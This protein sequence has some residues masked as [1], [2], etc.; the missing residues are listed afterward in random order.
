MKI[1][2]AVVTKDTQAGPSKYPAVPSSA[3]LE[4]PMTGK[5][6]ASLL[7]ISP[8]IKSRVLANYGS[9]PSPEEDSL[10]E[11][12]PT[13]LYI[14][15]KLQRDRMTLE[16]NSSF[17][18]NQLRQLDRKIIEVSKDYLFDEKDASIMYRKEREIVER[19]RLEERLRSSQS[20]ED[21]QQA[22]KPKKANKPPPVDPPMSKTIFDDSDSD[23]SSTGILGF[24]DEV[25]A[26]EVTVKGVTY[27]LRDMTIP[28]H[29]SGPMPKTLLRDYVAKRD[30]YAAISFATLSGQSRA[31]RASVTISWRG[32]KRDEWS[33]DDVAC[34]SDS[35]AEQY[36]S[37]IALHSLTFPLTDGFIS[38]SPA[39]TSNSTSFRLL[40]ASYRD[41][42]DELEASRKIRDDMINRTA[43]GN[44]Y[45]TVK[46]KLQSDIKV[47]TSYFARFFINLETFCQE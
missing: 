14:C 34:S 42:W 37:T 31:K 30:K 16:P 9:N 4:K 12:D 5:S 17:S 33:M 20:T 46:G 8:D 28:K 6:N 10:D 35:Q 22:I 32:N 2:R 41:L 40:P 29:W 38:S 39:S 19:S 24:L 44:I 43:W 3:E 15:L 7:K 27:K 21:A 47:C 11:M 25:G 18:A 23:D 45:N 36:I 26:T 1:T 13:L